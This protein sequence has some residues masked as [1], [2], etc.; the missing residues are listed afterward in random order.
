VSVTKNPQTGLSNIW[1]L[2][3]FAAFDRDETMGRISYILRKNSISKGT[4][5]ND[6]VAKKS[7]QKY[8]GKKSTQAHPYPA[9]KAFQEDSIRRHNHSE[10]AALKKLQRVLNNDLTRE[11]FGLFIHHMNRVERLASMGT[12]SATMAHELIQRLTVIHLSLDDILDELETTTLPVESTVRDLRD[13]LAQLSHFAS[14]AQRFRNLARKDSTRTANP[15]DLK[16][17]AEK[18]VAVLNKNARQKRMKLQIGELE[19]LPPVHMNEREVE[20]LF[21]ILI[22]NAIQAADGRTDRKLS[23]SGTGKDRSIELRFSDNCG[24]IAPEFL[25]GIFE[26]FFTTK[27]PDQGTGLGLYIVNNIASRVDGDVRVISEYGEGSTFLVT[28]PLH[29]GGVL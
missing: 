9:P 28:L 7:C 18:I 19:K 1:I 24:G 8:K 5:H 17:V 14:I 21:F 11:E 2:A 6:V 3:L 13:V 12:L 23:I 20:Q 15:I 29:E 10:K 27:P 25:E 16:L 26:P 4:F 22:E